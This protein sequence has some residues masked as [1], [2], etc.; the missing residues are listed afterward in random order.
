M[1]QPYAFRTLPDYLGAGLKLVL[2]GI[3]PGQYSVDR[4]HY[5]ARPQN[6]FWPA[7]SA[8]KLSESVRRALGVRVLLPEHDR[9]LPRFGIGLTDI[10]KR[11]TKN[12]SELTSAEFEEWVPR[13]VEKLMF[14]APGVV[15]FHGVTGYIPFARIMFGRA[16][17]TA[18]GEQVDRLGATLLYVVPNPSP[19]NA[20]CS[21]NE[22]ARW[23]DRLAEFVASPRVQGVGRLP[24]KT[25]SE[26]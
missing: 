22:Q 19:A 10:I 18:L 24:T 6:R 3:N 12:A 4:G 11:P 7:F 1:D 16:A 9:L 26:L 17:R 20:H 13:L 2:V 8:S 21:P 15:C 25:G 14:Y 23:Y 5:F